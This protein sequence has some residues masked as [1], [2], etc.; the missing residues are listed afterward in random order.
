MPPTAR[1]TVFT[2][3]NSMMSG[4]HFYH[5]GQLQRSVCGWICAKFSASSIS[6]AS[7]DDFLSILQ[8]F[9]TYW[10]PGFKKNHGL[11]EAHQS[12]C[13]TLLIPS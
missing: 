12:K 3:T 1:H 11:P 2:I 9:A 8:A 6:N 4:I 10:A 13:V 5:Y 7:H